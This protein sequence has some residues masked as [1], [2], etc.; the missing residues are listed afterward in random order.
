MYL[1]DTNVISELRKGR[2]PRADRN[3]VA[4]FDAVGAEKLFVSVISIL[5]LELGVALLE[6]RDPVQGAAL[7]RWLD[8][9]V[10]VD[11]AERLLPVDL[12]V[13]RVC[14]KLHVPDRR[15]ERDALIAATALAI[16]LTLVTRDR[17]D[18]EAT[19]VAIV[20]PWDSTPG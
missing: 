10:L 9:Q 4:W 8:T 12:N 19:G 13:A 5:E 6:R 17:K 1:L 18:F 15:P 11:F 3:V 20:N 14:A 16:G 2:T 7:R